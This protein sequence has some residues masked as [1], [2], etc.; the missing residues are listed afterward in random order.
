MSA[1]LSCWITQGTDFVCILL[2][3][4]ALRL[5]WQHGSNRLLTIPA[6]SDAGAGP[7]IEAHDYWD[8][9]PV[10]SS[11]MQTTVDG[12]SSCWPTSAEGRLQNFLDNTSKSLDQLKRELLELAEAIAI[13]EGET[14]RNK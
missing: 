10:S 14:T 5:G 6:R 8:G 9:D 3:L 4:F 11:V 1:K 2:S 7:L 12:K 13:K